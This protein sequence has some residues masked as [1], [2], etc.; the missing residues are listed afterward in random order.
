MKSRNI[1]SAI[2]A[3]LNDFFIVQKDVD[4][5]SDLYD[6]VIR[7][8][9]GAV[10]RKAMQLTGRSKTRAAK[11]LGISRNTLNSKIKSLKI[12]FC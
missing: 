12:E 7:E 1:S 11:I 9:E 4:C 6:T 5:V 8:V 10:I 3:L 2:E